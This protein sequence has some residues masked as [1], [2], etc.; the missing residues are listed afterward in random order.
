MA[1][2]KIRVAGVKPL[3][4]ILAGAI[5]AVLVSG[6]SGARAMEFSTV[7]LEPGCQS[8]ACPRGVIA[9]GEVESDSPQKLAS[10]LRSEMRLPGLHAVIFLHSPGGHVEGAL[11]LGSFLRQSGAAVVVGQPVRVASA[12]R[13]PAAGKLAVLPGR[14]A[15]ACVYTLMGGK[16]RVVTEG[17]RLGIHRMS[18]RLFA[19]DPAGG[20]G[21]M[22]IY[23][24]DKELSALRAYVAS[25]GGSMDLVDLA[26]TIPHD[27]IRILSPGE[28]RK[29]RLGDFKL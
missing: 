17:S 8:A 14:C 25:V 5:F 1:I 19:R 26:E 28:I 20:E 9:K 23:A 15:S 2:F 27:K 4:P 22:R 11:R 10:F 7:A 29:F 16:R 21:E 13:D 18:A 6:F 24:G 3:R 12:G